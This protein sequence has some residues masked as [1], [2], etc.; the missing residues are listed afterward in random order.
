MRVYLTGA[1]G[2]LGTAFS[3][4]LRAGPATADW[5]LYGVSASDFDIADRA[6]VLTSIEAFRPDVVVHTAAHAIVDDCEVQP[7][8]AARV[9]VGGVRHVAEACRRNGSRLIS[10]SSDYVF[11]GADTPQHGYA[12]DDL[13]SP[14]SVYGMTKLAGERITALLPDHVNVRTSWLFGG[15]DERLDTVLSVVRAAQRGERARL[16]HDQFSL[17]TYTADLAA[18]LLFLLTEGGGVRGTVHLANRGS[19]SWYEVG[20]Y[21][22]R[23]LG[24]DVAG[25]LAP[26]PVSFHQAGFI[27]G[28]PRNSTLNTDRMAALGCTLPT[29][30]DAVARFTAT[31]QP[32]AVATSGGTL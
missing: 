4:A 30:R 10:I 3:A 31:L 22:L 20:Q 11:D 14:L 16:I 2:M 7:A 9:N 17:P 24:E 5:P 1:D 18:S 23:L 6:A 26:E 29:W 21:V 12:E 15:G 19:A 8:L 27:G 13:P 32:T 28:R 25:E